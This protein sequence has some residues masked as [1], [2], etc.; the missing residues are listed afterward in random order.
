MQ[1]AGTGRPGT[2]ST[3]SVKTVIRPIRGPG[4]SSIAHRGSGPSAHVQRAGPRH[5]GPAFLRQ[6]SPATLNQALQG[7]TGVQLLSMKVSEPDTLVAI[8][9][10]NGVV[11][12]LKLRSPSTAGPDQQAGNGPAPPRRC[13]AAG[14]RRRRPPRGGPQVRLLVANVSNGS[15]Q[16]VH[17]IDPA[18]AAPL[19]SVFK[20]YVLDALGIA[21]ASARSAGTSC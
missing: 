3:G 10:A 18:A 19:G 9:S 6:V 12:R 20:L 11:P 1:L 2:A 14:R 17:S 15:C 21:V 16:P 7:A 8:V 5:F 13:D 4:H